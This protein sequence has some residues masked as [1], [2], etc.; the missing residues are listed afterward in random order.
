M[1]LQVQAVHWRRLAQQVVTQL[2]L[3]QAGQ[4]M[5]QIEVKELARVND[6]PN[7]CGEF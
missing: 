4:T 2:E 5:P 1:A 7:C 3:E 6:E